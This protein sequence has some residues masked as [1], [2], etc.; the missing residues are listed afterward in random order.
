MNNMYKRQIRPMYYSPGCQGFSD[1]YGPI[2][3]KGE[4]W[5]DES[6]IEEIKKVLEPAIRDKD[7]WGSLKFDERFVPI[8]KSIIKIM[9]KYQK[10]EKIANDKNI[11]G[12]LL[13]MSE[14][15]WVLEDE[16]T[17]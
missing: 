2:I 16:K 8:D 5:H 3:Y 11:D 12:D 4:E 17:D 9:S 7:P 1:T 14:I 6:E 15:R 13:R 10:I